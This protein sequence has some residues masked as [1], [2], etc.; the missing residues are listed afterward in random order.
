[1]Y[2]KVLAGLLVVVLAA[3]FLSCAGPFTKKPA[4]EANSGY[5]YESDSAYADNISIDSLIALDRV[6]QSV[7][8]D[9]Q[10]ADSGGDSAAD[11]DDYI[12]RE[13]K[14]AEEYCT[15]GVLA[16]RETA[17][18][19]AA[20]YFEKSLAILGDLDIDTESDSLTDSAVKY[21]R[22]LAEV[23]ANY[24]STL[25][26]LGQLSGDVSPDILISRFSEINHIKVD[27][28]EMKRL[29]AFAQ[30]KNSYN[31]PIVMNDRVK[32][33]IVYY[34][35]VAR[36]AIV[37]YLSR[38]TRYLPMIQKIFQEYG[39]PTDLAYLAMVESGFNNHAYSW[40]RAMGM[41]QFIAETGRLYGMNRTWWYDERKDPVK[42]THAAARFLKDLYNEFG[43]WELALA[44]Y[45]GGPQRVRNV[46]KKQKTND[47][48]KL[49]LK[50]QTMDY[51]PFFMAATMIC[52]NPEKFG[53]ANIDY[54]PEVSYDEVRINKSLD[55]KVVA[56]AI[57]CSLTELQD[58]NPELLRRYTPPNIS[59]YVLRIPGGRQEA[60]LASYSDM[61]VAQ[62]TSWVQHKIRRGENIASIARKYGISQYALMEANNLNRRSRII[63]GRNLIIP[64]PGGSAPTRE[65]RR[66]AS[67][68]D[69]D[70]GVYVVRSGDTV[71][72]IARAFGVSADQIRRLNN[73]GRSSRI[74]VGQRLKIRHEADQQSRIDSSKKSNKS[75][76]QSR[77]SYIVKKGDSIWDIARRFGITTQ[78]L[79]ELNGLNR[80]SRIYPGQKLLINSLEADRGRFKTYTVRRGDTIYGI[81]GQ[82][83]TTMSQLVSWNDLDNPEILHVGQ[84]I[85]IYSD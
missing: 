84:K 7:Y 60:F 28:S 56:D 24:R 43:S 71:S 72:D 82:F 8:D 30:E 11:I 41:W 52:K 14:V 26:S 76:G 59:Q 49:K 31:V 61:P 69:S 4:T 16:N 63:A 85:R 70:D 68:Y 50:K 13:L 75:S 46:T 57:G 6:G 53:F 54:Q 58:L 55:L 19:E 80:R 2:R 78:A 38:M 45:N 48:W 64:V 18:E 3:I 17:W 9:A 21:N 1:M 22:I 37:R 77:T 29:E 66:R 44:A 62:Q 81:A 74:Y 40:A 67:S 5:D 51:V 12:W 79:Q 47:F 42:S 20:Y 65:S 73:L 25:V 10:A 34:Q 15:M 35:T 32:T 27:S 33:C 83:N 36:D 23:A 39:L